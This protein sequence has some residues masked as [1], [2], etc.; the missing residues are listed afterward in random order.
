MTISGTPLA[1]H[2]DSVARGGA[3]GARTGG[4]RPRAATWRSSVRAAPA[5]HARPR[6]GSGGNAQQRT[7]REVDGRGEPG[8][9][10]LPGPV[11]HA[12]LAP[13]TAL[14]AAHQH[15][16]ASLIEVRLTQGERFVDAQASAPQHDDE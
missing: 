15:A 11:V 7:D 5:D 3:D 2:L 12:D 16:T 10:L 13:T 14:A 1:G 9:Q 6:V 4:A 8:L